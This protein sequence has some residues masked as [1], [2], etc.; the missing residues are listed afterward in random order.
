MVIKFM[1]RLTEKKEEVVVVTTKNCSYCLSE[2]PMEATRC[3]HC[4]SV[5]EEKQDLTIITKELFLD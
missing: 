1:S 3:P 4:T 5:L 2:I